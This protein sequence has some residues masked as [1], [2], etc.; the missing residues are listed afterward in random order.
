MFRS[1]LRSAS[2]TVRVAVCVTAA[3]VVLI[4]AVGLRHASASTMP[5]YNVQPGDTLWGIAHEDGLSVDALAA[6][7]H[8]SPSDLLIAG[9]VL[10]IPPEGSAGGT[11]TSGEAAAPTGGGPSS[12]P[13]AAPVAGVAS[14]GIL[15]AGGAA[16]PAVSGIPAGV[17]PPLL[18]ESPDRLALQPLFVRWADAYGVDPALVE[19]VAW[20]ESGW[21]AGVLSADGAIGIGQ[22]LPATVQF[23][24]TE[25]LGISLDP[26]SA[27]D[28]IQMSAR[29]L[30][31]LSA[32]EGGN[33]C[34]TI[35]AYY[36]GAAA[37]QADGVLPVSVPYIADVEA[38]M[39]RFS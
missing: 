33:V 38:L 37:V 30:A 4:T 18:A 35:A 25:L 36:Q 5:I 29:Y 14:A 31:Y 22:L 12:A 11:S 27:S 28:N 19:A 17:L 7:N 23:T 2:L 20:E 15:P 32:E 21:Q 24:E 1:A 8:M 26:W 3:A 10:V 39:D 34:A 13:S 9:R 6:A 16:C